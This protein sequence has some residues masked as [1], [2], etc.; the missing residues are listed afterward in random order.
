MRDVSIC[1][2]VDNDFKSLDF[3]TSLLWRCQGMACI[4]LWKTV[5]EMLTRLLRAKI[6]YLFFHQLEQQQLLGKTNS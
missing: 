3:R 1:W 5:R 4:V 6:G 2:Q